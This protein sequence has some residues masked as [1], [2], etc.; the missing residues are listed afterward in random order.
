M[1]SPD[2]MTLLLLKKNLSQSF[3]LTFT[4]LRCNIYNTFLFGNSEISELINSVQITT[5]LFTTTT[6]HTLWIQRL[7]NK[8]TK[9]KVKTYLL[10]TSSLHRKESKFLKCVSCSLSIKYIFIYVL[11]HILKITG[12]LILWKTNL[13]HSLIEEILKNELIQ[14]HLFS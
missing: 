5:I 1:G 6:R 4:C 14:L 9:L 10:R 12:V 8:Q 2:K 3:I 13:M 11:D 7:A